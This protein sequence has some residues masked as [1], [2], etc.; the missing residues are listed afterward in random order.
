M[1]K[2]PLIDVNDKNGLANTVHKYL[3]SI[4]N[5]N[6]NMPNK[7]NI[8]SHSAKI[9]SKIINEM[10]PIDELHISPHTGIN[11]NT[12]IEIKQD[13]TIDINKKESERK[14]DTFDWTPHSFDTPTPTNTKPR[15][16]SAATP[17]TNLKNRL[18]R[19][20]LN[21][22]ITQSADTAYIQNYNTSQ[23]NTPNTNN[24]LN[25]PNIN[26]NLNGTINMDIT[27]KSHT[28]LTNTNDN[29]KIHTNT[30][31]MFTIIIRKIYKIINYWYIMH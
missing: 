6:L 20:K 9:N 19:I 28:L 22:K 12:Q 27:S 21:A 24:K 8:T 10:T 11:T 7:I 30:N 31:K 18:I 4:T 15:S 1:A 14:S 25:L 29:N 2:L 26:R 17:K 5:T 3:L 16:Y 23:P 13:I